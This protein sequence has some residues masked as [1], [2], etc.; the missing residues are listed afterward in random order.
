[1][2]PE[3]IHIRLKGKYLSMLTGLFINIRQTLA[4]VVRRPWLLVCLAFVCVSAVLTSC[5]EGKRTYVIG[6]SQC[7]EDIW[8][9][10]LNDELQTAAYIHDGVELH[11]A[12]AG[13]NDQR[14][15][16]QVNKFVDDGVDLL[17]I[18]PNQI[19]TVTPAVDR[20]FDKGIPVILFDRKTGSDKYTA[21]IGA[22]NEKIGRTMGEY[23][24]VAMKGQG[25][26]VEITGLEGSSP[27]I[28]RHNGFIAAIRKYPGIRLAQVESGDWT[29]QS[30]IRAATKIAAS[31]VRPDYVFAHNDRMARGAWTVM[32]RYG[33]GRSVKYVGVDALPGSKGGIRLVRDGVLEASYIYPTRGDVVMNLALNILS[34]KPY[35][36][37][38]YMRAAI[39]T[40]DNAETL[41]MQSEETLRASHQLDELHGRVDTFFTQYSH[42]KVYFTLCIVILVLV[43]ITLC[44]LYRML[45]VKRRMERKAADAKLSLFTDMSH[46]LRTPLTLIADPVERILDDSNLTSRQR[47]M[48][49]IVR[50][51]A[52]LLLRLVSEILDLRKVQNGKMELSVQTFSLTDSVKLW[53]ESFR[54]TAASKQI[55]LNL[56]TDGDIDICADYYKVERI[57]Y[58]LISNA[59]K[60][61]RKGGTVT[62]SV[63]GSGGYAVITV[64]DTGIG[65][66][67]ENAQH[68]FEKFFQ[69]GNVGGSTGVGLA[70]VKAFAEL[71]GGKVAVKSIEGQGSE[72]IVTLPVN[73]KA[74]ARR[75]DIDIPAEGVEPAEARGKQAVDE[76]YDSMSACL[77]PS[78]RPDSQFSEKSELDIITSNEDNTDKPMVLMVDDNTDVRDYVASLLSADYDVRLASDGREGLDTALKTVPDI[79][80]CDVMM[81]VMDGLEMCR[82]V[83][84]AT[85]TSHVPVILLTSQAYENQ[86]AEGYDCGADAYITKPFSSKVLLSRVRNLLDGRKRLK[87][88]YGS[89]GEQEG[90]T[91]TDSDSLFMEAFR[92]AVHEH[93]SDSSLNVETVSAALGLSRVQ[94][95]RKIKSLTGSSPV[96]IIRITRLKRAE[97]LLKTTN[98]TVS[99]ISYEVGFSSPSYFSKCFKDFFGTVP[100]DIRENQP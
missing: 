60:Y 55:A 29:E 94:L 15:S 86:R 92:H 74:G 76:G 71:H 65:M 23:I 59:L 58:N 89:A 87:F 40:K 64:A 28:E 77:M 39:V 18:S 20:A 54:P 98:K 3:Y 31:G 1:M 26:V 50:R 7:S 90:K 63:A 9:D 42:Q 53:V 49:E 66:S 91:P 93:L 21:F 67:K 38:N 88:I 80:I 43:I 48:L 46:D 57:C 25:T 56:K 37:E 16:E 32:R 52:A 96:E 12:S 34:G 5:G 6:V 45:L 75:A 2:R 95:Y 61:N 22:D 85:A 69:A 100:G 72:F 78:L 44:T 41:L 97:Q 8:R 30:G 79:I 73:A 62:V 47:S 99:E 19:N 10:K 51:N 24:A 82:R 17:I 81:P 36:R 4:D 33:W 27:A 83:K 14:Q 11:F 35:E 13:D 68:I 70:I 84:E